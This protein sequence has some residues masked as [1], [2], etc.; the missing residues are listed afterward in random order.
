MKFTSI[1]EHEQIQDDEVRLNLRVS[2]R[3]EVTLQLPSVSRFK[4]TKSD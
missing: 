3:N 1:A 4:T 2:E